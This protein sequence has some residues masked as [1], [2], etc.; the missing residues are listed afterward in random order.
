MLEPAQVQGCKTEKGGYICIPLT[1]SV[2][3]EIYRPLSPGLITLKVHA[4]NI[5]TILAFLAAYL[6]PAENS[7]LQVLLPPSP[8]FPRIS[9]IESETHYQ[10]LN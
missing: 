2:Y 6:E 1:S 8:S 3:S 5:F 10:T 7:D 9:S 4:R